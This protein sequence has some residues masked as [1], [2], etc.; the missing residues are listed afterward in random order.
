MDKCTAILRPEQFYNFLTGNEEIEVLISKGHPI[1]FYE[2]KL[3]LKGLHNAKLQAEIDKHEVSKEAF[4][5]DEVEKSKKLKD[6]STTN[7]GNGFNPMFS[8]Y[9]RSGIG[10][11]MTGMGG[12]DNE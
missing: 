2:K 1:N 6:I 4:L 10:S 12:D 8:K 3:R 7:Y 11:R 9:G 5:T